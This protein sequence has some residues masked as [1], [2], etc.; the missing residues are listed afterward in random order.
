MYMRFRCNTA[1]TLIELIIVVA[2]IGILAGIVVVSI[3]NSTEQANIVSIKHNV[4]QMGTLHTKLL[5]KNRRDDRVR[6]STFC[7]PSGNL[8]RI[9]LNPEVKAVMQN[10]FNE[11]NTVTGK[12]LP[13]WEMFQWTV[14]SGNRPV[15]SYGE[16]VGVVGHNLAYVHAAAHKR[17]DPANAHTAHP[18][19]EW[20]LTKGWVKRGTTIQSEVPE[21]GCTSNDSNFMV[22]ARI[23]DDNDTATKDYFCIDNSGF[24]GEADGIR[25]DS[26]PS[27]NSI[28]GFW[29]DR[30][31]C[32]YIF[33]TL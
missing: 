20:S 11:V 13:G 16:F 2:I 6:I 32:S 28:K 7:R 30:V 12:N 29:P 27:N 18:D 31:R 22:W 33:S 21:A 19:Y 3:G 15:P 24:V 26:K 17:T 4:R 9:P 23:R 10:I 8:V 1:F 25:W 5:L 14:G